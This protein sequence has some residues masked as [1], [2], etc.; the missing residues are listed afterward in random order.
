[1]QVRISEACSIK[2]KNFDFKIEISQSIKK[3]SKTLANIPISN[4]LYQAIGEYLKQN[5]I[6]IESNSYLFLRKLLFL[7]IFQEKQCGN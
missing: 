1:M 5:E 3:K 4:R 2:C 6:S 7:D